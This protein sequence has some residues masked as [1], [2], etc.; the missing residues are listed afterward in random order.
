MNANRTRIIVGILI[1]SFLSTIAPNHASASEPPDKYK[2]YSVLDIGKPGVPRL[3]PG[4]MAWLERIHC[5]PTYGKIWSHLRFSTLP[6]YNV[7]L[8]VYDGKDFGLVG[9]GAHVIGAPCDEYFEPF[10]LGLYPAPA[11]AA[12]E[13]P[14]PLP[15]AAA[16][17]NCANRR[18]PMPPHS[19]RDNP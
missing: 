7:P 16:S 14:T 17:K 8:I 18:R 4:Q 5:T 9:A 1:G 15:V 6:A 12:C 11:D 13:S 10:R 19:A 3:T 2:T